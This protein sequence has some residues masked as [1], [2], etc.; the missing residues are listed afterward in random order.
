[1]KNQEFFIIVKGNHGISIL[2]T[3]ESKASSIHCKTDCDAKLI[4]SNKRG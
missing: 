1:M 4:S 3:S 2:I